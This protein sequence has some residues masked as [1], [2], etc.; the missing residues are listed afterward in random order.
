MVQ[1]EIKILSAKKRKKTSAYLGLIL[2]G[3]Q[4]VLHH[5]NWKMR[6]YTK[7]KRMST[8]HIRS[9]SYPNDVNKT[10]L[11]SSFCTHVN[12][13]ISFSSETWSSLR[14]IGNLSFEI[15]YKK[16][17]EIFDPSLKKKN[18]TKRKQD[19]STHVHYVM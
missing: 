6:G 18:N 13:G 19:V 14:C 9:D 17:N 3:N 11:C 12:L 8:Q 10:Y 1:E 15:N 7:T 2:Q 5:S 4:R 16:K